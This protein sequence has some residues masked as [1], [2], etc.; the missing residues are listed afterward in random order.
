M[1]CRISASQEHSPNQTHLKRISCRLPFANWRTPDVSRAS[2]PPVERAKERHFEGAMP[3]S[4]I[5][6]AILLSRCGARPTVCSEMLFFLC[7]PYEAKPSL[8]RL[9]F[10]FSFS[11]SL[12]CGTVIY[13]LHFLSC[14]V[15]RVVPRAVLYSIS[16]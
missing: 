7:Q 3:Q 12:L 6:P 5:E 8:T 11:L 14:L 4:C 1:C 9:Q 16:Q 13:L 15:K 2:I 10:P